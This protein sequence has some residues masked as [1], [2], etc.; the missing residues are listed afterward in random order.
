MLQ[1]GVNTLIDFLGRPV[2]ALSLAAAIAAW[3]ILNLAGVTFARR[4]PDLP[5]FVWLS[6]FVGVAALLMTVLILAAQRHATQLAMRRDH[7][8]LQLA[9]VSAQKSAKI[10]ALLEEM[11]PDNPQM[12]NRINDAAAAM[13]R[14]SNPSAV[15]DAFTKVDN[16]P[17]AD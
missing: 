14:S 1:R 17:A 13:S 3:I 8:T 7:L 15:L 2:A 12:E 6:I 9:L 5:P 4:A 10:I 11:R 16:D